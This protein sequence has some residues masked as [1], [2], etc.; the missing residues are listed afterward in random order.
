MWIALH[1]TT[2]LCQM[3]IVFQIL[4]KAYE[5]TG[6]F[7]WYMIYEDTLKITRIWIAF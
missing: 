7:V 6:M 4:V 2:D 5:Y 3:H 1:V